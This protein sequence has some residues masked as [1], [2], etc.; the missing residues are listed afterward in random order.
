MTNMDKYKR[1]N[2]NI[3]GA[4]L[5]TILVVGTFIYW[6]SQSSETNEISKANV[7]E[8]EQSTEEV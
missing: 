4:I 8:L 5:L 6:Q 2:A 1:G 3:V 7:G